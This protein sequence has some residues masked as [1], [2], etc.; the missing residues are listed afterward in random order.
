MDSKEEYEDLHII[1]N[2]KIYISHPKIT[3]EENR[4][5]LKQLEEVC[6]QI[7]RKLYGNHFAVKIV[8]REK[9]ELEKK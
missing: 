4:L 3:D 7:V 1:E 6:T 8:K 9:S 2:T 5:R